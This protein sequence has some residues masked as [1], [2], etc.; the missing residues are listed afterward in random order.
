M[1]AKGGFI[2]LSIVLAMVTV[3]HFM[4]TVHV[5]DWLR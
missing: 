1:A 3:K 5:V 4:H 2:M